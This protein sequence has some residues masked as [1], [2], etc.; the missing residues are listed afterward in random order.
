M[1]RTTP[2][3]S[4][5]EVLGKAVKGLHQGKAWQQLLGQD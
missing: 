1:V 5:L 2:E 3:R 4:T